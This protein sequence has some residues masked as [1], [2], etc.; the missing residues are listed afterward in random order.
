MLGILK[1]GDEALVRLVREDDT[2]Y[3]LSYLDRLSPASKSRFAPH[4]FDKETVFRICKQGYSDVRYYVAEHSKTHD[5]IA[6]ALLKLGV[7]KHDAERY[8]SYNLPLQEAYTCTYAPS[9]ADDFQRLGVGSLLFD[10]ILLDVYFLG[11]KSIILWGGVQ[12]T[13]ENATHYYIKKGFQH[14]GEFQNDVM[15]NYDMM[16]MMS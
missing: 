9:V 5:I 4:P 3:L 7:L 1:N 12:A 11:K 16:Y 15:A 6:Y 8:E 14:V 10:Y 13:N 2:Q